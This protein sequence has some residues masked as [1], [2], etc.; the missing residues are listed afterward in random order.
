MKFLKIPSLF[1]CTFMFM[2]CTSTV[3]LEL[4]DK[5]PVKS[6][7]VGDPTEAALIQQEM[8][9][10]IKYVDDNTLYFYADNQKTISDLENIGY[11]IK[12]TNPMQTSFKLVK[13]VS[14]NNSL[15]SME[16]NE[17]IQKELQEY[18][19]KVLNREKGYWAIY[20]SLDNL[21]RV[22]ELGYK[23]QNLETEVRPRNIEIKVPTK[24]DIQ[25]VNEMEI[26]IYSSEFQK[27]GN[28]TIF[29]GAYDYQIDL[30]EFAGYEVKK[31][32]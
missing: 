12:E 30:L 11:K 28:I 26:D 1:V 4:P 5:R 15:L 22:R 9:I 10:E 19:I 29:G 8:D 31:Q 7:K 32:N 2:C 27:E 14:K 23:I 24:E 6:I 13:L 3:N 17:T 25:K 20:G 21:S 18:S 16:K